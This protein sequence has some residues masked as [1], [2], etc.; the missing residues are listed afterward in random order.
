L[1]QSSGPYLLGAAPSVVDL[2][3]AVLMR[4]AQIFPC[5]GRVSSAD[6]KCLTIMLIELESRP[7]VVAACAADGMAGRGFTQP[8]MARPDE[9]SVL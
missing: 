9:G 5:A 6:Y 7:A 4:W 2:Y 1:S 3:V 8:V